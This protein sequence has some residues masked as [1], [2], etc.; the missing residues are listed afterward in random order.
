M[1]AALTS[2]VRLAADDAETILGSIR[3]FVNVAVPFVVATPFAALTEFASAVTT[4]VPVVAEEI[5]APDPPPSNKVLEANVPDWVTT[6]PVVL[7]EFPSAVRTPDPV[8]V[9]AGAAPAPPPI[10]REF[11]ARAAEDAQELALLKYGMPPDVPAT[12]NAS[13]PV[14]VT[15][16]PLT[17]INPP[18]N[19]CPT[20]VTVPL[21]PVVAIVIAPFPFVIEIPLP[22]V[23]VDFVSVLPVV[24]PIKS[25]PFVY[26]S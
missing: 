1:S 16:E 2:G 10:T 15:G 4:P 24:L 21:P 18:V 26:E 8:V 9:V 6:P 12:V 23:R 3:L 14:D 5:A 7:T 13:V 11:A 25:W 17:E 19:V 20:E 22:A